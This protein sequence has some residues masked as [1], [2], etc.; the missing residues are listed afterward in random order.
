[1]GIVRCWKVALRAPGRWLVG[2][3]A[4]GL[5]VLMTPVPALADQVFL[6]D[7]RILQVDKAEVIGDQV[8]IERSGNSIDLP[9]SE[10][11]SIHPA[12]PPSGTPGL[13]SPADTY[14]DLTIQMNDRLRREIQGK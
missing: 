13:P 14:R 2:W 5:F 6:Q 9:R 1:M 12:V 11:L 8:R 10:V 4:V 3:G 7:G